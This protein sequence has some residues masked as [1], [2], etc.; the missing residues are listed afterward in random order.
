MLP[1]ASATVLDAIRANDVES[2]T[3]LIAADSAILNQ[4]GSGGESLALY[5]CYVGA[6]EL[7]PLLRGARP[8]DACESAA[9]G[10]RTALNA[11]LD[12]D[13]DLI[14]W[15]SGDG[16]TPLHLAAFF[17]RDD[18]AAYLIDNGAPLDAMSTNATRNMPLHAALACATN[19][20]LVRRLI[21]AG[22]DVEARGETGVQPL[23]L[24]A[25]RGDLVLCDLLMSRGADP[26]AKMDDGTTP[27]EMARKRGHEELAKHL[28]GT[29]A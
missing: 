23:H 27:A 29:G 8:F 16:W 14:S 5:A 21:F 15:R 26:N 12:R 1:R 19:A 6:P 24:A 9:L 11:A 22:A 10:D 4:S 20:T 17:G 25:S 18:C 7:A 28:E 3:Q 13:A 2:L